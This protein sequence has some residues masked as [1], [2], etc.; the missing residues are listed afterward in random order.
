MSKINWNDYYGK[1]SNSGGDERGRASGGQ[2][3]DQTWNEWCIR[4]WYNRPWSCVLRYPDQE[5][6]ELIAELGI[7]A[8]N[9]NLIGYDQYERY[10]YWDHLKASNYR[11]SQITIPCESDCSA[12]V[13]A[14]T[15]AAGYLLNIPALKNI[16]ATYTGNM[17][18]GFRAA[19]FQVLTDS[20][21]LNSTDYL[22]PGDIL[23]NDAHHTATNLGI[24]KNVDYKN[25]NTTP[26]IT[27]KVEEAKSFDKAIAGEYVV[28][29]LVN[30][31]TGPAS[32]KTLITP[33][34]KGETVTNYG[35]Y[36]GP[37]KGTKWMLVKYKDQTGY[38]S[39]KYLKKKEENKL[40]ETP[41]YDGIVTAE[42]LY[43]RTYA[44]KEYAPLKTIPIIKKNQ[45]IEICDTVKAKD[46]NPW[47][48]IRI[49]NTIYGFAS[50]SYIKKV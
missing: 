16:N 31:R 30:L 26:A 43:V 33:I 21:Y 34:Q 19:G 15:R 48:Y 11:P 29:D 37:A 23:L 9:N 7:E 28:I 8:A 4:S 32:K 50:A 14:N 35:Y 24:G 2:A 17:R 6:R 22:M 18:D 41:L 12:G 27:Q 20:K 40:N 39:S 5:V 38:C 46:G 13:I 49:N 3:G 25:I 1:I 47:Y 36:T 42:A 10:T 44:G 45:K